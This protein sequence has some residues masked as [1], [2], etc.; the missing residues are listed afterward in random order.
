MRGR[1][2]SQKMGDI[3]YRLPLIKDCDESIHAQ[4]KEG[5]RQEIY[6]KRTYIKTGAKYLEH[7]V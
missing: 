3:I 5:L 4:F 7:L 6:A 2:K 1:Q